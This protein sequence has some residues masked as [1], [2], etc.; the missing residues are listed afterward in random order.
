MKKNKSS[1]AVWAEKN[2]VYLIDQTKLPFKEEIFISE[3]YKKTCEA[4]VTMVTRGAGS[5]GATAGFA[6]MQAAYEAPADYYKL[7]LLQAKTDGE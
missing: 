7:F 5:I 6:M 3:N 4:I 2:K 1:K